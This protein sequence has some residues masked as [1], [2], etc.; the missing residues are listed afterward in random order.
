MRSAIISYSNFL[1]SHHIPI[2]NKCFPVFTGGSF[3]L[4]LKRTVKG[5]QTFKSTVKAELRDCIIGV[6][7]SLTC[8]SQPGIIQVLVEVFMECFRKN[9]GQN[10][11]AD[12]Q[13]SGHAFQRNGMLKISGDIGYRTVDQICASN[14]TFLNQLKFRDTSCQD[15]LQIRLDQYNVALLCAENGIKCMINI[16]FYRGSFYYGWLWRFIFQNICKPVNQE[17]RSV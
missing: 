4:F 1:T 13:I 16:R 14:R 12:T 5:A 15:N 7:K 17:W 2:S 9:P 3:E 10:I 8:I 6:F 11:L